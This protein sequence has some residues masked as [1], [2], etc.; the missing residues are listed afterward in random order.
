MKL[1]KFITVFFVLVMVLVVIVLFYIFSLPKVS[2]IVPV[3]NTEEYIEEC[4]M[5]LKKQTLKDIEFIIIDDGSTDKSYEIMQKYAKNDKRFR[6]F[7]QE[8]QGVGK[9]RNFGID[10]ARGEYIG[11][12]DSDD[13]VSKNYF[14]ELYKVADKYNADMAVIIHTV[15][16]SDKQREYN[17]TFALP[18]IKQGFIENIDF[19]IGNLGQQWDKIYKKAFLEKYN[20]RSYE[21]KLWFEDVWFSS[22]VALYTHKIAITDK[23]IYYYRYNSKGITQTSYMNEDI[24]WEGISLYGNLLKRIWSESFNEAKKIELTV[25][26]YDKIRWYIDTYWFFDKKS[27]NVEKYY[28]CFKSDNILLSKSDKICLFEDN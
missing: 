25:R 4:L 10:K 2:V 17:Y 5:S 28:N 19:L 1:S 26:I 22:L 9:T 27:E 24:F 8:N 20:I 6:I 16:F 21:K 11:F 12:V 13:Y 15:K 14:E 23:T 3:Y 18:Y 7:H